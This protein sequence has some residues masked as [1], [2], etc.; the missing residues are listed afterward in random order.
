ME[1]DKKNYQD[2]YSLY[3]YFYGHPSILLATITA[4]AT[5]FSL[6][7]NFV[8]YNLELHYLEYWG[9]STSHFHFSI[10]GS[11]SAIILGIGDMIRNYE[12]G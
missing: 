6:I 11:A 12:F 4:I 2:D 8:Y 10:A 3:N 5:V 7:A 1:E 9:F